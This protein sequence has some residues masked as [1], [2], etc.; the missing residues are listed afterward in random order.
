MT[1][2]TGQC[3]GMEIIQF[4]ERNER[5]M[6]NVYKNRSLPVIMFGKENAM[7]TNITIFCILIFL[8][9]PLL[10]GAEEEKEFPR[11]NLWI[12]SGVILGSYMSGE[13]TYTENWA[14][15]LL[16]SVQESG[17][18]TH[19]VKPPMFLSA[20]YSYYFLGDIGFQF[21]IDYPF[22]QS[23]KE[24]SESSYD[25]SWTWNDG[26]GD[27]LNVLWPVNGE[28]SVIPMH[29]NLVFKLRNFFITPYIS[30]GVTYFLGKFKLD[31]ARGYAI[32]INQDN[33]QKLDFLDLLMGIEKNISSLGFNVG[34]GIDFKIGQGVALT[35]GVSYIKAKDIELNWKVESGSYT[36]QLLTDQSYNLSVELADYLSTALHPVTVKMTFFQITAGIKVLF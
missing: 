27:G 16:T 4:I 9:A 12:S 19:Q 22:Q 5:S 28:L 14:S 34:G 35:A 29:L 25:L 18:L 32:T 7:K 8:L 13:S 11:S 17:L 36:G 21:K 24:G 20:A 26:S 31:S 2:K 6:K 3:I 15:G 10:S 23:M 30:A 1:G 33:V